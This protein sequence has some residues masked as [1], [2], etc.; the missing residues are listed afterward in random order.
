[1]PSS[2]AYSL[3]KPRGSRTPEE[4][5]KLMDQLG[6]NVAA[7]ARQHQLPYR[8]VMELL[9]GRQRGRRGHA[10]RAAVLL[11]LKNGEIDA[12]LTNPTGLAA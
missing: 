9:H 4:A 7:W 3:P 1:M 12:E 6:I 11:G 2:T 10:H 8:T 5:R